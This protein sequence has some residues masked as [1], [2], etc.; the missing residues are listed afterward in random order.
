MDLNLIL[1][2]LQILLAVAFVGA[3]I[4]HITRRDNPSRGMEWVQAVPV[5]TMTT[6]S[7]LE[8]LGGIGVVLP[9]A[10]R[11]LPVLTPIA[12]SL[13]ALLMLFAAVFHVRRPGEMQNVLVNVILGLL[14]LFVAYGRFVLEPIT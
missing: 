8:I 6:I 10:T 9:A 13:L 2:I 3:G 12:A 11:I 7:V 14:A 5:G 1:W 4:A